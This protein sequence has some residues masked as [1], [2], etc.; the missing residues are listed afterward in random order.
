[1][2]YLAVDLAKIGDLHDLGVDELRV[3]FASSMT[4]TRRSCPQPVGQERLMT[5]SFSKP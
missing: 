1:M 5:S 3:S 2:K 4:S